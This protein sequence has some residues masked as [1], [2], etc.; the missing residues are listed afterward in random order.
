MK[1][2][3]VYYLF[4]CSVEYEKMLRV[5]S[6]AREKM[7]QIPKEYKASAKGVYRDSQKEGLKCFFLHRS[8]FEKLQKYTR[9]PGIDPR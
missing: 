4:D 6:D 2:F 7:V 8:R 9:F 3:H 1:S 5:V